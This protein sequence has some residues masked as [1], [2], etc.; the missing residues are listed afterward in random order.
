M[1]LSFGFSFIH[2]IAANTAVAP[3]IAAVM[4]RDR[5]VQL[6]EARAARHFR[7]SSPASACSGC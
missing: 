7:G 3:M 1:A 4:V 6:N 2:L 5:P